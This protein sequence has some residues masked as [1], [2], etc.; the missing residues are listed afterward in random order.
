MKA[1][2]PRNALGDVHN[3]IIH[4]NSKL[5]TTPKSINWRVDNRV[6]IRLYISVHHPADWEHCGTHGSVNEPKKTTAKDSTPK[7]YPEKANL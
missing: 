3:S 1:H 4:D 7:K 5:K 6:C 2:F